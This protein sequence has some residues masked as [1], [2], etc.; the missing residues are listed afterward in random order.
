MRSHG[1]KDFPGIT[2]GANG[3]LQL[4]S[5]GN[6][7][8]LSRTYRDAAKSCGYLLPKGSA[9]PDDPQPPSPSTPTMQFTC[10]DTCPTPPKA[11]SL[12]DVP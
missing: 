6:I 1:V 3:Q 9:L 7:D 4:R 8:P 11:P 12:P 5:G 10:A 2:I